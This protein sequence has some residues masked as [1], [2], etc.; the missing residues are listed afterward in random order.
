SNGE[1][2]IASDFVRSWRRTMR[3]GD[4]APHTELMSNIEGARQENSAKTI[5]ARPPTPGSPVQ[6]QIP[7]NNSVANGNANGKTTGN[8]K[9]NEP[10]AFGV[11]AVSDLVLRVRLRRPDMNFPA[12]V[13]HPI[14][15]PVKLKDEVGN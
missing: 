1:S 13:A 15:R 6:K 11:E 7:S 8:P 14:F 3:I 9:A 4:L 12:L 10:S 5:A 2:V